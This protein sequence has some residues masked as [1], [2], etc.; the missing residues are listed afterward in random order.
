MSHHVHFKTHVQSQVL[1]GVFRFGRSCYKSPL[2][3]ARQNAWSHQFYISKGKLQFA[4]EN[5]LTLENI[6]LL[7]KCE[8]ATKLWQ[9]Y[10]MIKMLHSYHRPLPSAF[11]EVLQCNRNS[12]HGLWWMWSMNSLIKLFWKWDLDSL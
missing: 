7:V 11:Q 2:Q 8:K 6:A 9:Q 12:W 10:P 1:G 3:S 4:H 5:I